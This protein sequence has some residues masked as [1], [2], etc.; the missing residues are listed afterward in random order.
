M[1]ISHDP[2]KHL[3]NLAQALSQP[4]KPIGFLLGAGCPL[5]VEMPENEWPLI[6]NVQQLTQYINNELKD[7]TSYKMLL[8]ELTKSG[9]N[10][11]NIEDI[12]SFV[13]G[14]KDVSVGGIVR[15][16]KYEDLETIEYKICELILT[17]LNKS[18]PNKNT[19]YHHLAS[20]IRSID[21]ETP[22][23]VFTTNYDLL[24]EQAFEELKNP[25]FDGFV[26]VKQPFFDLRAI[27][28]KELIAKHNTRLWKIHG[29][30]NWYNTKEKE[31]YRSLRINA[32]DTSLIYPSHLKYDQSRKMPF[33]A[34]FDRLN[35]FLRQK[36]SPVLITLGYS[37]FDEHINYALSNAL[38]ANPSATV[39]CL[40]FGAIEEIKGYGR[41]AEEG[42]KKAIAKAVDDKISNLSIWTFDEAIIGTIRAKWKYS[43]KSINELDNNQ[44]PRG[45]IKQIT[46]SKT[47]TDGKS[48]TEEEIQLL[49]LSDFKNF[50]DFL[51]NLI[52]DQNIKEDEK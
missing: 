7:N 27:E 22:V 30:I 20:W 23:E 8:E 12:L 16:L 36:D 50:G 48:T 26:G 35:S 52:G 33:L 41:V 5:A 45:I 2:V 40:L 13:R 25:Y 15:N 49:T 28:E 46:V 9:K 32:T 11:E 44:N 24:M 38:T 4:K 3:R 18:L 47:D 19:P 14:L 34:M 21:R 17:K 51:Q 37:F 10:R 43:V 1:K 42:Y 6:P 29:S 31:V 39:I